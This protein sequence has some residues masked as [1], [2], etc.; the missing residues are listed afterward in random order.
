[1]GVTQLALH[2]QSRSPLTALAAEAL[3][4][5]GVLTFRYRAAGAIEG[6]ALPAP[7]PAGRANALWKH[8][9]FEAFLAAPS[10]G[11]VELNFS[12]SG[13]WAA[14]RFDEYRTGM[15]DG[16]IF[17]PTIAFRA[18]TETLEMTVT[19]PAPAFA[20]GARLSLA[21]VIE[22]RDGTLS[23]WALAHPAEKPDFH[24]ADCFALQLPPA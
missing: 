3:L 19:L 5:N 20:Y 21:A 4:E 7:A 23:Y 13:Q 15:R 22:A 12:P 14:Y 9:C 17:A 18:D 24:R 8:T 6:V 16:D 1:V 10:G 2:P 11:Y